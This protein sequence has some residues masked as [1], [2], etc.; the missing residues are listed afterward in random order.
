MSTEDP[1]L[2]KTAAE[3]SW[4]LLSAPIAYI[5]K[6]ATNSS[7]KE[8][9]EKVAKDAKDERHE[10]RERMV[11]IFSAAEKD[12]AEVHK[13]FTELRKD[14]HSMHIDLINRIDKQ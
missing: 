6:K 11:E 7:S 2:W 3:Y 13:Q 4:V 5:W 8:D 10:I 9:L 12:R 1:G 14:M